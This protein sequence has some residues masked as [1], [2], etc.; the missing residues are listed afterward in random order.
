MAKRRGNGEGSVSQRPDGR[1]Q[2]QVTIGYGPDGKPKRRTFYGKSRK[3]AVGKMNLALHEIR[4]GN[5]IEP[6]K[7]TLGEWMEK[8]LN[9]YKKPK[10]RQST[11]ENYF[12]MIEAHI[13]TDLGGIPLTKLQTH[14]LQSYYNEKLAS[15]RKDGGGGLSTRMVRYLHSL[16]RQALQQ[17]VKE[18]LVHKNVADATEPPQIVN[19]Q[20]QP[21]T[22]DSLLK[23]QEIAKQD[24]LYSAYVLAATTG[25]RRGELL[26]LCWDSVDLE[27][28]V[29]IVRRQLIVLKNGPVLDDTTKSKS[30]RRSVTLTDDAIRELKYQKTRQDQEKK[31]FAGEAYNDKGLVFAKEG[32]QPL[33]PQEF[34]KRFQRLLKK[35][36]I[37]RARLHDL[38]Y[39]NLNK[40]QTF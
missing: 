27:T 20:M 28:G 32:G 24:H 16:I 10:L 40:I 23:F 14:T 1:W 15:G 17:A 13:K 19:K 5:Y 3:E 12:T 34:T 8:W 37:P 33:D 26:G 31:W 35:A 18:G 36:G 9:E 6:T 2:A 4:T 11:W 30:G 29:L 21:L 22:E 7:L 39:P 38:R 25:L